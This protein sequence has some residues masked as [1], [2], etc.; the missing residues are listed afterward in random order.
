MQTFRLFAVLFM[1][2]SMDGCRLPAFKVHVQQTPGD[3]PIF[4]FTQKSFF[5]TSDRVE[6]NLL[7]VYRVKDI[8]KTQE[9]VWVIGT[10]T[11]ESIRVKSI[12]Y[13]TVP[14]GFIPTGFTEEPEARPLIPGESYDVMASK[15]GSHGNVQFIFK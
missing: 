14:P 9:A 4:H 3:M 2:V 13:G 6:I 11:G 1:I 5:S 15:P 12:T 10:T 8:N 7:G